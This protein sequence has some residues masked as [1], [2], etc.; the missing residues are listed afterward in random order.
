MQSQN[1]QNID[2]MQYVVINSQDVFINMKELTQ[3]VAEVIT[4]ISHNYDNK[5]FNA[6]AFNYVRLSSEF[7]P[8]KNDK[9]AADWLFVLN[10]LNFALWTQE[11]MKEWKVNGLTG[12]MALCAAIKRAIDD[13]KPMWDPKFYTTLNKAEMIRIFQGDDNTIIPHICRRLIILQEVGY[14]LLN[15][16]N[17]T[18]A[19]CIKS[20]KHDAIQLMITIHNTFPSY[21]DMATYDERS[22]YLYTKA[23]TL[24]TD[25]W[26]YFDLKHELYIEIKKKKYSTIFADYRVLHVFNH[27]N[28]LVY[29]KNFLNKLKKKIRLYTKA[30]L[31]ISDLRTYFPISSKS[32]MKTTS[33]LI[34]YRA[35]QVLLYFEAISY[36][37]NFQFLL[38][39][40]IILHYGDRKELEIRCCLTYAVQLVCDEVWKMYV[41]NKGRMAQNT[42][43]SHILTVVDNFIFQYQMKHNDHLMATVPFHYVKNTIY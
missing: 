29:S 30:K 20:C 40:G 24:V 1:Q 27:F 14:I 6:I 42:Q 7:H 5:N 31:L 12:Y 4:Y 35:I 26:A 13:G 15:S 34:D 38:R 11:N 32:S 8:D 16:Y 36:T 41:E 21:Y 9:R 23:W 28:V 37:E 22:V 43:M 25:V 39:N 2:T 17:G 18:F 33:L 3:L 19:N 10:T